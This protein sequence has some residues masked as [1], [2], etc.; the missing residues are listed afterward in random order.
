[1]DT[2]LNKFSA[3][4][5]GTITGFDR[6]T[7]KGMLTPILYT[8]GIESFLKNKGVL[9]KNFKDYAIKQ[10]Q[11]IVDSAEAYSQEIFEEGIKYLFSSNTRK[12]ELAHDRQKK[13]NIEEGL[14]G[15][16][17][18]VESCNT[19]KAVFNKTQ[20]YPS[21]MFTRSKCKHLYFYFDD[22]TYGFMSV[23]LQT[24]APYEIQI[25]L[26]GR[27]WLRRSLDK[28]GCGYTMNGNKFL[29][30][31]DYE[32]A[33]ELLN[34]QARVN[35]NSVL[36]SFLPLV[37]PKMKEVL[38]EG[39]LSYY[40]TFWQ[41]EVATDYIFNDNI[42]LRDLMDDFQLHAIITGRGERILKYF[43][44]P[45]KQ[46]G[47]PYRNTNPGII[48][49]TY[50]WYDGLRVKHWNNK[51]SIKFYNEHNVFRV[52]MTMNDPT[53]FRIYRHTLN[54]T[55]KD[56]KKL[57]S[58]RKGIIDT[59]PRFDISK[60]I[61]HTFTEHLATVEEKVRFGEIVEPV[62]SSIDKDG[63]KYRGLDLLGKD[64]ILLLHIADPI[65]DVD[66]ITN[67]KLQQSIS[68]TDWAK[69]MNKKQLSG[70]ISRHLVLLRKHGI[71]KK[72]QN[73][74]KYVLTDKGRKLTASLEVASA[75]SINDLLKSAA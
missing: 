37:F 5:N 73:Q 38:N 23:R 7:F 10:S 68:K 70:R 45:I 67:K 56:P 12:E 2:L 27:E 28:A 26:N 35:F 54:Q 4:V 22:P 44:T 19:Y 32:L 24:W 18:C 66:P 61:I 6:I 58:L 39:L 20:S 43:G 60:S 14:I 36:N 15:I 53:R 16:W 33:Q 31:N 62:V 21:L 25:A 74:R 30:I 9:N 42:K 52:E 75:S 50:G 47:L 71:I 8:N 34:A 63:K 13:K 51:N 41:T 1:M 48:T 59:S 49:K 29:H 17:A 55:A 65:Y 57:L 46:D 72:L 69:G 64:R 11:I 40:W 3:Y